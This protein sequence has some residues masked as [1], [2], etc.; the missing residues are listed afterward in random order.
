MTL[1]YAVVGTCAVGVMALSSWPFLDPAGRRGIALAAAVALPIQIGS[2][3]ALLHVRTRPRDFLV[4]WVGGTVLRM[5]AIGIV[6]FLVIRSGAEGLVP[7]LIALATFFFG[8]LLL[9]PIYFRAALGE[10]G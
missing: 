6:A 3:A 7:T 9:E 8:L 5:A 4:T 10:A 1:R 2:F